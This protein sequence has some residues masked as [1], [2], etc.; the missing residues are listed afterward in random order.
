MDA[1]GV[2]S[3]LASGHLIQDIHDA[4]A[5]VAEQV[6]MTE[7][8]GTVTVTFKIAKVGDMPAVAIS[9]Q[10]KIGPPVPKSRG[11]LFFS[12]GDGELHTRDPRQVEMNFRV[13]E[14]AATGTRTLVDDDGVIREAN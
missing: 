2:I 3:K 4:I 13:V 1:L 12:V 11:A 6:V 14:D 7:K 9:E 5:G 10:I 8:E